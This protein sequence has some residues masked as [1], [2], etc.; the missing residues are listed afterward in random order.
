[1]ALGIADINKSSSDLTFDT[2]TI[3]NDATQDTGEQDRGANTSVADL[4]ALF[5]VTGFAAAPSAGGYMLVQLIPLGATGGTE[6]NDGPG[7]VV[8]PVTADALYDMPAPL[9]MP[10]GLRYFKLSVTNKSGQ[11]TDDDAAS[12]AAKWQ[13]VTV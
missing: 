1:M 12:L 2:V 5:T 9:H 3:N 11:N 7:G 6:Y 10:S 4:L 13:A 8:L